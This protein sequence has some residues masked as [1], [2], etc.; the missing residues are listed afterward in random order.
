MI[1][2]KVL[3]IEVLLWAGMI[4]GI[5][6]LESWVKFRAPLLTKPIGLDVG[7]TVFSAFHKVQCVWLLL[8]ISLMLSIQ[9]SFNDWILLISVAFILF[10]QIVWLHPQLKRRIDMIIAGQKPKASSLHTIYV[11]LELIKLLLLIILG[12]KLAW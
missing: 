4:L 9:R 12:V 5:S 11:V 6:F 7:R 2:T 10:I 3:A 8:A 1:L